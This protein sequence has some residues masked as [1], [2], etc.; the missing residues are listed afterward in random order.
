LW[1][2]RQ[3]PVN[4]KITPPSGESIAGTIRVMTDFDISIT[5]TQGVYHQWP[6]GQVKVEIEDRL[7]GHRALLGKYTDADIH[8]LTA[9]LVTLK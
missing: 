9:Y 4:V 3:G 6:R 1:P 7:E 2:A 8:N 5:D